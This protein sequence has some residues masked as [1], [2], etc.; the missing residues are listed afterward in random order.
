MLTASYPATDPRPPASG[1]THLTGNAYVLLAIVAMAAGIAASCVTANFLVLGLQRTESDPL[2]RTTLTA[3]GILMVICEV[4]AFG[5]AG[6]LPRQRMRDLRHRLIALGTV[7]LV[8]ETATLYTT[9]ITLARTAESAVQSDTIRI[10]QL[11]ATIAAQRATALALRENGQR[12]SESSHSWVRSM[13]AAT[14]RQALDAEARLAT[15]VDALARLKRSSS[16]TLANALS[17][18]GMVAYSVGR[19]LLIATMGAIMCSAAGTLLRARRDL[20]AASPDALQCPVPTPLAPNP[21]ENGLSVI[22]GVTGIAASD[23]AAPVATLVAP[24]EATATAPDSAG[25]VSGE[26]ASADAAF[27]SGNPDEIRYR[28]VREG[29]LS[30][31]VQPST[32]AIYSY[33]GA[34]Q[35]VATRYLAAMERAGELRRVGRIYARV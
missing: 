3:T 8:F 34:T 5:L 27:E 7:L 23:V 1:D 30:G 10:E 11:Q 35:R 21:K 19:S 31:D 2:M 18:P 28:R 29:I 20:V 12:Q 17:E 13:G 9:Q 24:P 33:S 4:L 22:D 6:V 14:L 15:D 16:P 25:A 26:A 32:R